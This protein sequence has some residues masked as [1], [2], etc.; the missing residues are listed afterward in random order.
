MSVLD[1]DAQLARELAR[2]L[3]A[4]RRG[5]TSRKESGKS[6]SSSFDSSSR[7]EAGAKAVPLRKGGVKKAAAAKGPRVPARPMVYHGPSRL[8]YR[9][10]VTERSGSE[11]KVAWDGKEGWKP[12]WLSS[13]ST[14]L[15]KGSMKN[16]DWKYVQG[17]GWLPK[18]APKSSAAAA[19]PSVPVPNPATPPLASPHNSCSE[20]EME[21]TAQKIEWD[22]PAPKAAPKAEP[23]VEPKV[24]PPPMA[25]AVEPKKSFVDLKLENAELPIKLLLKKAFRAT[26]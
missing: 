13:R 24:E 23:K 20:T 10:L 21:E 15:W 4:G 16:K 14:R 22:S 17:G 12:V 7:H 3:N 6:A 26:A 19:P 18:V 1:D 25:A 9:C 11:V 5:R 2:E 8:W